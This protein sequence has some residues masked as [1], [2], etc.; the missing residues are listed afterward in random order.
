[1]DVGDQVEVKEAKGKGNWQWTS[2]SAMVVDADQHCLTV[3]TADGERVR[4]VRDH[5]R[6]YRRQ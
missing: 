6:P 3:W 4:D 2:R 5:F 1:M